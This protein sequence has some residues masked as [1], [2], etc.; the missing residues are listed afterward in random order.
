MLNAQIKVH[1]KPLDIGALNWTA[2]SDIRRTFFSHSLCAKSVEKKSANRSLFYQKQIDHIN[3][4]S[5]AMYS[6]I[7]QF[8]EKRSH[9]CIV[10]LNCKQY[11]RRIANMGYVCSSEAS[12]IFFFHK[13]QMQRILKAMLTHRSLS[14][15]NAQ[16]PT[17]RN[18]S[19]RICRWS[20]RSDL[21]TYLFRFGL[22]WFVFFFSLSLDFCPLHFISF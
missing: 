7:L 3:C 18:L 10:C 20:K 16:R 6:R 19:S 13:Y 1:R 14:A 21:L 17:S 11:H 5:V 12:G 22:A 2:E 15:F 9:H 4:L 8:T